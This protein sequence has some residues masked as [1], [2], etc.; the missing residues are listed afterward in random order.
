MAAG[1]NGGAQAQANGADKEKKPG[2]SE[3]ALKTAGTIIGGLGLAGSMVVI[4]SA[5]LWIRFKE[6]GLPA[7]Q[8]VSVQTRNEALVQGA[9]TT[10]FF[11]LAA[12][13]AVAALYVA[14]GKDLKAANKDENTD[15][16][17]KKK[18]DSSDTTEPAD[19]HPIRRRALIALL[20]LPVLGILWAWLMTDLSFWAVAGL[21]AIA[22]ILTVGC[23]WMGLN[24][25]KNFWALAAAVFVSVLVFAGVA[26]F[27]IV[28]EQKFIQAVAVLRGENDPGLTGFYVTADGH[29]LYVATPVGAKAGKPGDVSIQKIELGESATYSVGPL[30]KIPAA[31]AT[32]QAM[33][34]QLVADREGQSGGEASLPAWIPEDKKATFVGKIE[35]KEET[36]SGGLCLMRFA[37]KTQK[38][39]KGSFWTS[40]AEAEALTTVNDARERL[41]LPSRFQERYEVR[42]KVKVPGETKLRYAEGTVAPQCAGEAVQ[43]CG[44]R[45]PGGGIQYW[46][47]EKEKLGKITV[48][49]TK[50]HNDQVSTWKA[51]KG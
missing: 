11:V 44:H 5:V 47:L 7:I 4:G 20:I 42:V 1:Q 3:W 27:L 33:L 46:I 26:E 50:S 41:A 39:K 35:A 13:A 48:E 12:L 32:S 16:G 45:Y 24:D 19:W 8:A 10:I 49:C 30:E 23:V 36:P 15:V 51:C 43:P 37:E 14:D 2:I 34:E 40:C 6:A 25:R 17:A 29:N 28:K 31:E 21:A 9:Q 38:E 22:V 18:G